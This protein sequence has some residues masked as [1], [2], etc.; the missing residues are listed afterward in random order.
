[1]T[2]CGPGLAR[3]LAGETVRIGPSLQLGKCRV[4]LTKC[5]EEAGVAQLKA[6]GFSSAF[7]G[8]SLL[9]EQGDH[10]VQAGSSAF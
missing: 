3:R 4:I 1:M 10:R 6:F 9:Q 8:P 2:L 7:E 5:R